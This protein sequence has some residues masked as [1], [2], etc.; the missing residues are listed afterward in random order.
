MNISSHIFSTL[1]ETCDKIHLLRKGEQ[2]KSVQK[3]GFKSLEQERKEITIGNRM[4]WT[5]SNLVKS[6]VI[7]KNLSR[8]RTDF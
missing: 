5:N 3:S 4:D 2:I 8:L 7:K 6:A 1:S